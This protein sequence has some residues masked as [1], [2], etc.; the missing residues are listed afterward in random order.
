MCKANVPATMNKTESNGS[1]QDCQH[2]NSL[3]RK[4]A[5][6]GTKNRMQLFSKLWNDKNLELQ[7]PWYQHS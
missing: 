1:D 4:R 7:K 6:M 3:N 5:E 2:D